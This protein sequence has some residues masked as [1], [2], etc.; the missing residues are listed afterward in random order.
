MQHDKYNEHFCMLYMKVV[1]GV[2]PKSSPLKGKNV[3]FL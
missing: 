1:K 2:N 3:L